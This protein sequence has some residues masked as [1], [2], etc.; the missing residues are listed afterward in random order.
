MTRNSAIQSCYKHHRSKLSFELRNNFKTNFNDFTSNQI[1]SVI[2]FLYNQY[3]IF[4]LGDSAATIELGNNM[5]VDSNKKILAMKKWFE[6]KNYPGI[7]DTIVAYNSLTLYYEPVIIKEKS[8]RG[9]AFD[10]IHTILEEA[11]EQ[12]VADDDAGILHH[13]PV[14]YSEEFGFDL[15]EVGRL[16]KLSVEKII[17]LHT[18]PVYRVYMLG[19][20]PG[21]AYMGQL[22]AALRLQRKKSP[23]AV[24]AGS[25]GIVANQTGIYPL[26]S[27]GG[28]YI[29]G[30]TPINLFDPKSNFPVKF[31][32]GDHVKFQQVTPEQ[33][34]E[35]R[36]MF[37]L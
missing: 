25:V 7:R 33:F 30:R 29:I 14:C 24:T 28:W 13:V 9:K 16:T 4:P 2:L 15:A 19:F 11:Y 31:K 3:A 32:P 10:H 23:V 1:I 17:E 35:L 36:L 27:P 18:L 34:E 5:D 20:L 6:Q 8:N 12:S 22:D 26:K 37:K 21:F